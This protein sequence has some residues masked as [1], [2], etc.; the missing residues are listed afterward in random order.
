MAKGAIESTNKLIRQYIPK[1]ANFGDY[2]DKKIAMIQKKIN[3]RPRQKLN[4]ETPK[5]E[6]YKRNI[7]ILHLLVDSTFQ[8]PRLIRVL[9][10]IVEELNQLNLLSNEEILL[11]FS[12]IVHNQNKNYGKDESYHAR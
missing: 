3:S 1:Q 10:T 4:F 2:T 5:N 11:L 6:F 9:S 7:V 12:Q 8:Y